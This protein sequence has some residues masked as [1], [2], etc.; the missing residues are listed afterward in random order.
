TSISFGQSLNS[1]IDYAL[2][3]ST[4]VKQSKAQMELAEAQREESQ[5]AQFGS[6]DLVG[7]YTHF[8]LPRTLAPLTP[9]NIFA[10][11]TGVPT[12]TDLF[13]TGVMYS[14]PLFTGFAQTR[15]VEMDS[16]ATQLSQSKLSLTREQLAYN[17]AS[18][19]LSILAL[20]DMST[21]QQKHVSALKK[22]RDIIQKEV[23][24]GK[25]AQIDLLKAE[26]DLY[27][28]ISYYEVLK[29]N[30][31]ITKASLASLV[32]LDHVGEIKPIK[33]T[34]KK[35]NYSINRLIN[36]ASSLNKVHIAELNIKKA[37]KGVEKS[38]ASRYPQVSL[39]SYYGYNYGENDNSNKYP[40]DF[41][42]Q[43]N[44]QVGVSA[45]WTLFDFGKSDA[46][47][48]KAKIARMQATFEKK[49]TLL[50]LRKS[51]VEAYEKMKQEYANYRGNEKQYALAKKSEKIERVRYKNGVSTINDLLYAS[52]Q[53][54]IS[55]A[56]LIESKYNY[57]KGKFYMDYLLERGVK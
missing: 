8:N 44:W 17:V 40:G 56:K 24:L 1:L 4:I 45:K 39:D 33:V 38:R 36:K 52:S 25:K 34:V 6:I 46:A 43:E 19:Y 5:S 12:T 16:I 54:H 51:L 27:G 32:G 55:R 20:Q 26:N 30:I 21:A 13:G 41:N 23:S 15:Q 14:V 29:G 18:L 22:L 35:P 28:N 7:S 9:A 11:P 42:S 37:N 48:Q 3:H 49:Q 50:D 53:T 31:A 47:T 2:K 57:Q 10:D